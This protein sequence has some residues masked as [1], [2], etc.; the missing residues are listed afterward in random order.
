MKV[1]D[2]QIY[3]VRNAIGRFSGWRQI[4]SDGK[5]EFLNKGRATKLINSWINRRYYIRK[6]KLY[7]CLKTVIHADTV[8]GTAITCRVKRTYRF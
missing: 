6:Q 2:Q 1:C 5:L 7:H 8:Y 3:S 4:I